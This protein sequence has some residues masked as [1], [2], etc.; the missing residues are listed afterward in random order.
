MP[1][2]L[3]RLKVVASCCLRPG[4]LYGSCC[5]Q[6]DPEPGKGD[7][8]EAEKRVALTCTMGCSLSFH[9]PCWKVSRAEAE[10]PPL[11]QPSAMLEGRAGPL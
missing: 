9:L 7:I 6:V 5:C 3:P 4:P 2:P 11:L 8:L 10:P 1:P